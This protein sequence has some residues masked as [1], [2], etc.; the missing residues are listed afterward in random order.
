MIIKGD[1]ANQMKYDEPDGFTEMEREQ[2]GSRRWVEDWYVVFRPE[3]SDIYFE[4]QYELPLTEIQEG[5][6]HTWDD[7]EDVAL[8]QVYPRVISTVKYFSTPG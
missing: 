5:S 6:E 7:D 2:I 1:V 4:L 3:G 8:Q